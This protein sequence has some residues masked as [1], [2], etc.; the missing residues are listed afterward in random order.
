MYFLLTTFDIQTLDDTIVKRKII[1]NNNH[2]EYTTELNSQK[3][4]MSLE[5]KPIV[6]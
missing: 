2:L 1:L 5:I 6:D 3:V 4:I